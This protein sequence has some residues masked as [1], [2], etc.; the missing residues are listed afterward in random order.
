MLEVLC[1]HCQA[2]LHV[3]DEGGVEMI[4]GACNKP[5]TT[6]T[7]EVPTASPVP[8]NPFEQIAQADENRRSVDKNKRAVKRFMR[9][10]DYESPS[11]VKAMGDAIKEDYNNNIDGLL[12]CY[13]VVFMVICFL[14]MGGC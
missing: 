1:P 2:H 6:P 9:T 13:V 7:I 10:G 11:F 3:P 4:C 14:T 12:G 5:F 8:P